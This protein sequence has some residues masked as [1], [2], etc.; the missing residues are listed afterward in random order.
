MV[1]T[2]KTNNVY[3]ENT[4]TYSVDRVMKTCDRRGY[5]KG[6]RLQF[7]MVMKLNTHRV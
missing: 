2:S 1:K 3:T 4:T 6:V 5:N 7:G